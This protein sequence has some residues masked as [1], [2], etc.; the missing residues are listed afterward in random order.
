[1]NVFSGITRNHLFMGIIGVTVLLQVLIIEFLGKFAKT[2]RLSWK[3]WLVS[4]A[5]GV[6]SWPLAL[7]G[8]LIPVPETPFSEFFAP[9]SRCFRRPNKSRE[10]G[11]ESK[12][13]EDDLKQ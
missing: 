5:I 13:Q 11:H 4:V 12:A 8:K 2:V 6:I 10:N 9:V 3:L 7:I 1:M